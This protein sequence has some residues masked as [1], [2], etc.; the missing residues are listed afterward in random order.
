MAAA[1]TQGTGPGP[2]HV[3]V[4]SARGDRAEVSLFG[5]VTGQAALEIEECFLDHALQDVREWVLDLSRVQ[6]L[7]LSCAYALI[8]PLMAASPPTAVRVRGAGD[9]VRHTLHLTG[10]EGFLTFEP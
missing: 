2:D 7:D 10:A 4:V 8:R 3:R 9:E 6:R 5:E 1:A